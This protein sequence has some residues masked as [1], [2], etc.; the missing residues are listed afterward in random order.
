[1][2]FHN[3]NKS[4]FTVSVKDKS[5]EIPFATVDVKNN[6]ILSLEEKPKKNYFFNAGIYMINQSLIK[7]LILDNEKIDMPD[8]INRALKK[9]FK[10]MPFYHHEK[11][12]DF[13]TLREYLKVR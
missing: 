2:F 11:W 5:F 1:M 6:K 9:K 10:L 7:K 8:L 13:G 3:T 4:D 12:I